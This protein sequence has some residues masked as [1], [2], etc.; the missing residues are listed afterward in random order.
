MTSI[1]TKLLHPHRKASPE[2]D[3]TPFP[4]PYQQSN[5]NRQRL[6]GYP[7]GLDFNMAPEAHQLHM[8][9]Q[10]PDNAPQ[11]KF[12]S[13]L[14]AVSTLGILLLAL[15]TFGIYKGVQRRSNNRNQGTAQQRYAGP[16][17]ELGNIPW[18]RH[19]S[20]NSEQQNGVTTTCYGSSPDTVPR[21][22]PY[23]DNNPSFNQFSEETGNIRMNRNSM[24]NSQRRTSRTRRHRLSPP[25]YPAAA[26]LRDR[27]VVPDW[28]Y[29]YLSTTRAR[30]YVSGR[31]SRSIRN[32]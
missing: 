18:N 20:W 31:P 27:T 25:E 16:D 24:L 30:R 23:P 9:V 17:I 2:P 12:S 4:N 3:L 28:R 29:S 14:A 21:S 19:A 6:Q 5:Q 1:H 7:T 15:A 22:T 11:Q 13:L 8:R 10:T 32:R 26:Y